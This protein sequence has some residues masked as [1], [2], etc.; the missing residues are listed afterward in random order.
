MRSHRVRAVTWDARV[1]GLEMLAVLLAGMAAGTVNAIVG[2]GTL[3]T[4][5]VL[6][7][8]GYPP[9]LA[10]VS[11]TVGLTPGSISGAIGYRTELAGQRAPAGQPGGRSRCSAG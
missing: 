6:L 7:A 8:V 2:S 9:V 3:I 5:P 10:N 4:F 11:N 1:T